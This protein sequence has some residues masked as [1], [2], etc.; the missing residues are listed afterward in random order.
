MVWLWKHVICLTLL[1]AIKSESFFSTSSFV[2]WYLSYECDTK[3]LSQGPYA[4]SLFCY[5]GV[6]KTQNGKRNETGKH[7]CFF[8][9]LGF[10]VPLENFSL[11]WRRNRWRAANFDLCSALMAIDQWRLFSMPHLLWHGASVIIVISED[12]W[13]THIAE[14]LAV[15][16]SLPA[17]YDLG[18]L[19]L[20]FG[21]QTFRMRIECSNQLCHRRCTAFDTLVT[22]KPVILI[23]S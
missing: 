17:F 10:F 1:W 3:K 16:L 9:V 15:E 2:F 23:C 18:L 19:R 20:R 7:I 12:P 21:H 13:N 5:T 14:R 4:I 22:N 11:I 8:F 6:S